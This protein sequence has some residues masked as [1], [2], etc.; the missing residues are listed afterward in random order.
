M[1]KVLVIDDNPDVRNVITRILRNAGHDVLQAGNGIA[2]VDAVMEDHV[3]LVITDLFMPD[4]EGIETIQQIRE[5]DSVM[6]II[7]IS[8]SGGDEDSPLYD[9]RLMGANL[10]IEKPFS[11][12]VL[13]TGVEELLSRGRG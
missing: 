6:P 7:A 12:D 4:Q 11:V 2:G 1:A 8:G 5:I 10:T 3:E 9:A 13:L